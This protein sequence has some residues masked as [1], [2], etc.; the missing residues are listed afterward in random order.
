MCVI[1]L[2][3]C[4]PYADPDKRSLQQQYTRQSIYRLPQ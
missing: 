4:L 3:T 1:I 2:G